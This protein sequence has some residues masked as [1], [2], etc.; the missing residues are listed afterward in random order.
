MGAGGAC[1]SGLKKP[2]IHASPRP[3]TATSTTPATSTMARERRGD[4]EAS[5]VSGPSSS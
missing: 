2:I 3:S 5:S 1:A 4:R